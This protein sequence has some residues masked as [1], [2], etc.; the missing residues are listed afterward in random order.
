LGLLY[1]GDSLEKLKTLPPKTVDCVITSPPYWQKRSYGD[2]N[3]N[4]IGLEPDYRDYLNNV[5]APFKEIKRILKPSGNLFVVIGDSFYSRQKGTG[6]KSAKQDSNVGSRFK[7]PKIPK[8]MP[9]G[10]LMDLPSRFAIK[11]V[12]EIGW[13]KKNNVI[14]YKPNAM[15]YSNKKKFTPDFENVYHFILDTKK[16]F[17]KTQ[18]EPFAEN[19]DAMYRKKLRANKEYDVKEPYKKNTPYMYKHNRVRITS[20]ESPNRMWDDDKSLERQ[21]EQG[22]IKRCV[23]NIPTTNY[24]GSHSATYPKELVRILMDAGCPERG[25]VLDPFI[26]AGT[27]AVVAHEQSKNWIGIEIYEQYCKDIIKRI[28][29]EI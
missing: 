20:Q 8:L 17:F 14:W 13:I 28:R 4:E 22:R 6:G 1:L 23:W 11:M 29:E 26:G 9:D 25:T 3:E 5:I 21:L 16:Y 2:G 24:K 12:D 15:P 18:Y 10:A 19:S 7:A 27:T